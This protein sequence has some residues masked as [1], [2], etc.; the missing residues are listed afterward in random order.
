MSAAD[1]CRRYMQGLVSRSPHQ[2]CV[3]EIVA[4]CRS[5]LTI[6]PRTTASAP[7]RRAPRRR[8]RRRL[9][10]KCA[11]LEFKVRCGSSDCTRVVLREDSAR[12]RASAHAS[13]DHDSHLLHSAAAA[14]AAAAFAA[15][16]FAAAAFAAAAFAA[17]AFA[18]AAFAAAA[19]AAAAAAASTRYHT[20]IPHGVRDSHHRRRRRRPGD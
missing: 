11:A 12:K 6:F 2:E 7:Y 13:P 17:A 15:A 16:S 1:Y 9:G 10:I 4:A 8:R 19:N 18:A 20:V 3:R 14:F 5:A